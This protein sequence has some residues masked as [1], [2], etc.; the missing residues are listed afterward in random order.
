MKTGQ[1][2][3][4][5]LVYQCGLAN[6]FRMGEGPPRRVLQH[7]FGHCETFCRGLVEAG[8]VVRVYHADVA[9]DCVLAGWAEGPGEMFADA[10][11]PPA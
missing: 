1:R 8:C 7:A 5:A 11:S 9:G 3:E 10:K 4:Y 2:L 6:V